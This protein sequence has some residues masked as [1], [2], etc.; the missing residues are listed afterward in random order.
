VTG[1]AMLMVPVSRMSRV[2][3]PG[4]QRDSGAV[5]RWAHNPEVPGANPGPATAREC[6]SSTPGVR[7]LIL[8]PK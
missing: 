1:W 4:P 3:P 7:P 5:P 6:G 8:G 2:T